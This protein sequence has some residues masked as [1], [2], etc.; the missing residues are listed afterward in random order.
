MEK[1]LEQQNHVAETKITK[2][3]EEKQSALLGFNDA[4]NLK[5]SVIME[6]ESVKMNLSLKEIELNNL[7]Q[8][9]QNQISAQGIYTCINAPRYTV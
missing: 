2:L 9:T 1:E 6:L 3:E 7:I 8:S 5:N 4:T